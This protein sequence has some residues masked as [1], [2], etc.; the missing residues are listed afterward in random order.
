MKKTPRQI[1]S[2]MNLYSNLER[3]YWSIILRLNI[4]IDQQLSSTGGT[5]GL[6]ITPLD[7]QYAGKNAPD[8]PYAGIDT[9]GAPYADQ[10][11]SQVKV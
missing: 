3:K 7:A 11:T 8:A 10:D 1:M 2:L 9:P 4:G 6:I 5:V